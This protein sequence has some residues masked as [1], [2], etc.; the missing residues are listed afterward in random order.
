MYRKFLR[1][2]FVLALEP[3]TEKVL[4]HGFSFIITEVPKQIEKS[5]LVWGAT[6]L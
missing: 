4:W 1:I 5:A 2:A 3:L 6:A